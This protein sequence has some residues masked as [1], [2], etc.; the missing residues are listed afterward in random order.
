MGLYQGVLSLVFKTIKIIILFVIKL[1]GGF[2]LARKLNKGN[3]CVLCYHGFS[4]YDEHL[5]RP[6]LFMR[7]KSFAKRMA[8]LKSSGYQIVSLQQAIK[9]D[10][11]NTNNVVITIDDGWASTYELGKP[12]ILLNKLP[13]MLYV[14]SYYINK[15]GVVINVALAYILWKSIGKKLRFKNESLGVDQYYLIKTNNIEAITNSIRDSI[16]Q[17][18][19]IAERQAIV[20][21]VAE[22]LQVPLYYEGKL[23]FRMLNEYELLE[24]AQD[25]VNIQLHTHHHCSPQDELLFN[26]EIQQNKDYILSIMANAQLDHFCYPSGECYQ[27]QSNWLESCGVHSATTV[28]AGL[29]TAETD[30]LHIPRFLDGEDVHQLEFEAELCG[31]AELLRKLTLSSKGIKPTY[32]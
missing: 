30:L 32:Q 16:S 9:R 25:Q 18:Y 29:L 20:L 31:L 17:L 28:T 6:K 24:L 19:D 26:K 4:Y 3:T 21:E 8:W 13:T 11:E 10:D 1:L 27:K 15:Q 5:F 12:S 22:Q 2:W 14:T 7:P 23:L